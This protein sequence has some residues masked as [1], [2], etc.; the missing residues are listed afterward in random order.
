MT[1][2]IKLYQGNYSNNF[3]CPI[4]K[5]LR[6][7][8]ILASIGGDEWCGLFLGFIPVWG[9]ISDVVNRDAYKIGNNQKEPSNEYFEI[10]VYN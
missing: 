4:A 2:N 3:N 8:L 5:G 1:I 9:K 10:G 7:K 6:R